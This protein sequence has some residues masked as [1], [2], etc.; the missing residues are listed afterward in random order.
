MQLPMIG[1]MEIDHGK[2]QFFYR[3][4][5]Y[6]IFFVLLVYENGNH[7]TYQ[8]DDE[9]D[10]S[11][12]T[13]KISLDEDILPPPMPVDEDDDEPGMNRKITSR[14]NSIYNEY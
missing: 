8:D 4:N 1:T 12:H 3:W 13:R 2:V 6:F 14:E 5:K 10:S 7:S 9:C 11:S